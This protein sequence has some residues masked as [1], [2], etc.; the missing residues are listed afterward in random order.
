MERRK[1]LRLSALSLGSSALVGFGASK[2]IAA[3]CGLT[4][5]QARGPFYPG[6]ANITPDSD[7][8]LVPSAPR[9]ALGQVVYILGTVL[10]ENCAPV[11]NA[12]VEIWQAC[13]TGKYKHPRDP[14]PAELDPYFRYWGEVFT[15]PDGR[16]LFK[17]IAPG[18]YPAGN[19][20]VRP[21]H[22]HFRVACLGYQELVTQMYFAGEALNAD[23]LI[24]QALTPA[25][26]AR[27]VV[28]FASA[29]AEFAPGAKIGRFD[30]TLARIAGRQR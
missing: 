19:G 23:D 12:N 3:T 2:A 15:G 7:L 22:I 27:V 10:D 20:W 29:G 1:F 11:T 9:G 21:P 18:A 30:I 13:A 6:E 25:E 16:Y 5:P 28:D 4:P 26:R 24:L 17:T 8:T 14:N